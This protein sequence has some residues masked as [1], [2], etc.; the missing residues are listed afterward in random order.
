MTSE[1]R[2]GDVDQFTEPPMPQLAIGLC[3]A[4]AWRIERAPRVATLQSIACVS[5]V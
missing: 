4:T 5:R 2:I 1:V 3:A